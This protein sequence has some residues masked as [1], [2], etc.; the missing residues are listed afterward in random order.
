MIHAAVTIVARPGQREGLLQALRSLLSPTRVEPGCERCRLFE[1]IEEAGAF[2]L[3]EEWA[4]AA[5][6][7]RRLRSEAYRRLLQLMEL[8]VVPPE[9]RFEAVSY[10]RGMEAIYAARGR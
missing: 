3:V 8:S 6:F 5:D 9:V 2:T 7:E 4:T 10:T 1:D